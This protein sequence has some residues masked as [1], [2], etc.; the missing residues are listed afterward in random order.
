M[1]ICTTI[2]EQHSLE[3]V[4]SGRAFSLIPALQ[5]H[6]RIYLPHELIRLAQLCFQSLL[7]ILSITITVLF[8][9]MSKTNLI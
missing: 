4:Q 9:S 8:P 5:T 3:R 2:Y 1:K 7:G 6:F